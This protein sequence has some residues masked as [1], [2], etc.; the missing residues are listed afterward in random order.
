MKKIV[1]IVL[2][3]LTL[4]TA[5][6]G[7]DFIVQSVTGRV[8]RESGSQ[9]IALKAGD[10]LTDETYIH[11]GAGSNVVLKS[12]DKL[13]TI[14]AV[15]SGKISEL[16]SLSPGVRVSGNISRTDTSTVSRTNTQVGTASARVSD[17]AKD[18][19]LSTE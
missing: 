6:F 17:A 2:I 13:F 1:F 16:A 19:D 15:R 5:I 4:V 10:T 14:S 3:S 11:T 8:E 18:E 9:R 12:G 7:Q